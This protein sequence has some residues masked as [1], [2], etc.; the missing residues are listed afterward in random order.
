MTEK[1]LA[2]YHEVLYSADEVDR[3]VDKIIKKKVKK[4]TE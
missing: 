3:R 1:I 4:C 2:K